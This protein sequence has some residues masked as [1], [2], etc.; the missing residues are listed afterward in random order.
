[1]DDYTIDLPALRSCFGP[2]CSD[3]LAEEIVRRGGGRALVVC[4]P[5]GPVRHAAWL[6]HLGETVVGVFD[7]AEP[8]CPL[9]TALAAVA[10][11]IRS[12]ADCVVAIGGGSTLGLGK[13]IAVK[14]G[15]PWFALPTT[16]SGSEMTSLYGTK[17]GSEKRTRRDRRCRASTV[18]YDARLAASLPARET[19][20]T[21]MNCLAHCV[22]ALYPARPNPL[23]HALALQGSAI[24]A[25]SLPVCRS[26]PGDIAARQEA[27]YAGFLGGTL[28]EMVGIGM[29]HR[30]CHVIGGH[31]DIP[32]ADT[33]SVLLPQ[34][35]AFNQDALIGDTAEA[36]ARALGADHAARGVFD[37]AHRLGAPASLQELGVRYEHLPALAAESMGHIDHNPRPLTEADVLGVLRRAWTGER[38]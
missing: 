7:R 32:H 34:V 25:R 21:G 4:T 13:F 35:L 24:L 8:H 36:L 11:F 2:G 14:L 29:H 37:L 1:M 9:E 31:Y 28:V 26:E 5:S 19:V 3:S 12:E 23:A 20:S 33:N 18:F 30:I 10:S 16:F 17:I 27:L 22:E 6:E 15:K 38:P